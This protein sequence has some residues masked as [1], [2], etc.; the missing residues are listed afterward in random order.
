MIYIYIAF[1]WPSVSA[2]YEQSLVSAHKIVSIFI[3][4][5]LLFNSFIHFVFVFF[6]AFWLFFLSGHFYWIAI[7][8]TSSIR[9]QWRIL[10]YYFAVWAI[11]S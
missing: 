9:G 4:V 1:Q 3:T 7:E 6:L 2:V 10:E 5:Y 8:Q 11:R